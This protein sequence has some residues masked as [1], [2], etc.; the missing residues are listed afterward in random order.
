MNLLTKARLLHHIIRWRLTWAKRDTRYRYAVPGNAKFMSARDA[1]A[2]IKDGAVIATSGLAG[3]QRAAVM[4]WAIREVFDE[5]RHPANITLMCTG[6]QG[7]RG[8]VP[9]SLEELGV[10][11]LCARLITGHHETFKAMLKMAEAGKIEMQCLPQGVVAFL[12]DAQGKGED[13]ITSTTGIGTFVD[14]RVGPGSHIFDA[15]AEQLVSVENGH[16]RYR[17]P[18]IDVALFGAPA[19]DTE[20][21][22]YLR[23]A[24][25]I[26]ESREITRAAKANGGRVIVNVG[27][28]VKKGYA[29]IAIPASDVDAIV[30]D[31]LC[32]QA[33]SIKHRRH[34]PL[35]TTESDVSPKEGIERLRFINSV[36]GITPK[37]TDVDDA[38]ARLAA[39]VIVETT[40]PSSLLNIGVG[41]PEEVCRILYEAGI[42]DKMTVFTES[43]V[44]GGLPAPGIFFGAATC[45][46]K[47]VSSAE[48]FRLCYE[49]LDTTVLGVVEV[50]SDG[51]V[52]VSKRGDGPR[53]YVGPGGFIDITTAAKNIVFVTS[54]M[55][56]SE[57]ALENG[58][59]K[60][61]KAG[62]P[63]FVEKVMEITFCG[64]EALKAGK[65]V[66]Y[67][68]NVGVFQ[69]TPRGLELKKVMPGVDIERDILGV[70]KAKI[71]LPESGTV[72]VVDKSVVS[73]NGFK[74]AFPSN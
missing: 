73:G 66:F 63:K 70:S 23:H 51:N 69:L 33:I 59:V 21:N 34:W 39:T 71:V 53:N 27:R 1:V 52:N 6:G 10:E 7:S 65:N 24:S 17:A 40:K 19:A 9:G 22:I 32:E 64:A 54:W 26:G 46:T 28:I 30:V 55:A 2:L 61:R 13:S 58:E 42:L 16:L 31:P 25:V 72:P 47:I 48:A 36:L 29:E 37:R 14:P 38:L 56:R 3:N 20:G 44:I 15:N 41:L 49:K 60:I 57:I 12:M 4:Y 5:T 35:L 11:G 68:T 8:K 62:K 43:G 18:K 74:I 50:D 67:A 45:P